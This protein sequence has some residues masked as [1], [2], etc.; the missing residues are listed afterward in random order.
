MA[1][2]RLTARQVLDATT[3]REVPVQQ[4]MAK[5]VPFL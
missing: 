2:P 3:G 4:G 5:S 1:L